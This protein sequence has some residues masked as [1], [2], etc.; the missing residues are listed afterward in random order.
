MSIYFNL[1]IKNTEYL[2]EYY[3]ID[4]SVTFHNCSH[5]N[6]GIWTSMYSYSLNLINRLKCMK[7]QQ[8]TQI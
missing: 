6:L 4:F 2:L 3:F 7:F 5:K 8:K 1:T